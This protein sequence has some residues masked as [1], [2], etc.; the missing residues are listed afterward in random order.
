MNSARSHPSSRGASMPESS[1]TAGEFAAGWLWKKSGRF[2]S[3]KYQYFILRGALLSYYDKYPGEEYAHLFAPGYTQGDTS[4]RGVLRV[5]HVE[6]GQKSA[7]AFKVYGSSGKVLDIRVETSVARA[8]W[9]NGLNLAS[10][11][12]KRKLA[13]TSVSIDS[14]DS[15]LDSDDENAVNC[16]G[17]LTVPKQGN[18]YFVLQG[19][20]LSMHADEN[21]WTVPTSRSYVLGVKPLP[22]SQTL[23]VRLSHGTKPLIL[24]AQSSQEREKW[25]HHM[26]ECCL[27]R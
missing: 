21:P 2:S 25:V 5:V 24:Q 16:A 10:Q 13:T 20:M 4:P 14:A 27:T 11:L 9:V 1:S 19:N 17:Y 6:V 8:K 26:T 22:N 23:E 15:S 12:G 18:K 3:W 7:I